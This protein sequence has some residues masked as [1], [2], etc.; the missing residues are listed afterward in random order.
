M[1]VVSNLFGI[2]LCEL[3][4]GSIGSK[5]S[6]HQMVACQHWDKLNIMMQFVLGY[7]Q[8]NRDLA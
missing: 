3:S 8:T 5:T 1:L 6:G 7:A 4:M 2:L